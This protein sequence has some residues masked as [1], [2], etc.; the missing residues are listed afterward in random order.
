MVENGKLPQIAVDC[1]NL[2]VGLWLLSRWKQ[3]DVYK[4]SRRCPVTTTTSRSQYL[5]SLFLRDYRLVIS[6]TFLQYSYR[7]GSVQ[8]TYSSLLIRSNS[9]R[10]I[11]YIL[12]EVTTLTPYSTKNTSQN[13][14][15]NLRSLSNIIFI[16]TLYLI[17]TS[18]IYI[19][20]ISSTNISSIYTI[21]YP[22]FISLSIITKII[23][24]IYLVIESFN[25]S[26]FIIKS[27]NI[28]SYSLLSILT[29][30][31]LLYSLYLLSLFLQ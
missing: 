22:Y 2:V 28:V 11:R 20:P 10:L 31:N 19:L 4:I 18:L 26:N 5:S 27:Y 15:I 6:F 17:N 21:K 14:T 8:F 23:L 29:R 25:F 3:V 12:V 16:S 30:F 1:G 9:I 7:E 24:Y 13:T